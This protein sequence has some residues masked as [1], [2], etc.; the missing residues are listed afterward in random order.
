[1]AKVEE[2]KRGIDEGRGEGTTYAV[3]NQ[4]VCKKVGTFPHVL[5]VSRSYF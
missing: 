5:T 3:K 4:F 2:G 1:M